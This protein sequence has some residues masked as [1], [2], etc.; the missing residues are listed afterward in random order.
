MVDHRQNEIVIVESLK[1]YL[2]TDERPC[3]IVRQNQVAE[4]PPY[5]YI[6]YTLTTPVSAKAGMYSEAEDGTLY[7]DILQTWSFT[8][9][10]DDQ[11]EALSLAMK[12]YDFFS[13]V[14]I[15][16]LADYDITVRHVYNVTTRDNLIS[17]E[18][19]YRNGLDVV[20]GLLYSIKPDAQPYRGA[21]ETNTFKEV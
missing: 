11:E 12:M 2:S 8:A 9:Q 13:A 17:I 19:E 3:E 16:H 7:Q 10:S 5:P 15:T 4:V 20:F 14:A 6:S 21:I 18:Y 1:S